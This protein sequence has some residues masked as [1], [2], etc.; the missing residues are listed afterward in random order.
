[1]TELPPHVEQQ[2]ADMN[3]ADFDALLA[4]VRPPEESTDPR[5]RAAAALRR[6]RGADRTKRATPEEAADAMR[7]WRSGNE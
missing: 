2:L 3:E 5:E 1:V 6:H 7:R 4:R